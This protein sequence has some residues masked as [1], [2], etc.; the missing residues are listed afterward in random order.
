MHEDH[1]DT[2]YQSTDNVTDQRGDHGVP[3]ISTDTDVG[4]VDHTDGNVEH[5]DNYVFESEE[6]ESHDWEVE[7]GNFGDGVSSMGRE[8]DGDAD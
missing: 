5:V 8:P 4:A 1:W 6:Y 2:K 7:N 3:D